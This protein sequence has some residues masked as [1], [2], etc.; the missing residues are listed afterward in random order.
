MRMTEYA[1]KSLKGSKND[2]ELSWFRS[3]KKSFEPRKKFLN[4]IHTHVL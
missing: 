4:M 2:I 1:T 3:P